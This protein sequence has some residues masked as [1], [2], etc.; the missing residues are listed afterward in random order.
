MT[1]N[2]KLTEEQ[3]NKLMDDGTSV[4]EMRELHALAVQRFCY[5]VAKI[6]EIVGRKLEWFDFNN[7]CGSS[8]PADGHFDPKDFREQIQYR[9]SFVVEKNDDFVKYDEFFPTVWLKGDFEYKLTKEV[10]KFA[11]TDTNKKTNEQREKDRL[12]AKMKAMQVQ[13]SAKL[14]LEEKKIIS[15]KPFKQVHEEEFKDKKKVERETEKENMKNYAEMM[16]LK[17]PKKVK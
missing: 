17:H 12:H 10:E 5:I 9:G 4:G 6:G 7:S 2:H 3:F 13:I 16:K 11:L 14:T 1:P 15:F 8:Y